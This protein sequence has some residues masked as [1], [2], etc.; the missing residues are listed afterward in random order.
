MDITFDPAKRQQTLDA[1]GLD[2]GHCGEVFAG[3]TMTIEDDR[4]DY[5][6]QRFQTYGWLDGRMVM[7]VWTP[8][9]DARRIISMRHVHD[10][11]AQKIG[12]NLV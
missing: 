6:E 8:R 7:I 9:P 12:P 3:K 2:F 1:R 10:G 5:G 4:A 11:Q